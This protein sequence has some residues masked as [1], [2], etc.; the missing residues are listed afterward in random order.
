[1]ADEEQ[2]TMMRSPTR[3]EYTVWPGE[4]TREFLQGILKNMEGKI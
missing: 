4:T 1:M 3:L 2:V